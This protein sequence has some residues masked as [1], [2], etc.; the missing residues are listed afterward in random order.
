MSR[1]GLGCT[2]LGCTG[3]GRTGLGR[4]GLGRTRLGGTGWGGT[5]L[6]TV[7]EVLLSGIV[8]I[9]AI[10]EASAIIETRR[11]AFRVA[12]R[13]DLPRRLLR[14]HRLPGERP[15]LGRRAP[16]GR[17]VLVF[18]IERRT[19]VGPRTVRHGPSVQQGAIMRI[20]TGAAVRGPGVTG[21][22]CFVHRALL[23]RPR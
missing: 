9:G 5:G 3:L 12:E 2:G 7:L 21:M 4:T 19:R 14:R 15:D 10:V 1:T 16:P 18:R 20:T 17:H 11:W 8:K 23:A 22:P 6:A 13:P